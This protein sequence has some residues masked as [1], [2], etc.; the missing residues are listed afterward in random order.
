MVTR[1]L[2]ALI[3]AALLAPAGAQAR[4]PAK[5]LLVGCERSTELEER[6]G[7][8]EGEMR[9]VRGAA[10]MQM[11]FKLQVRT[12]ERDR[13]TAVSAPGFGG[14]LTSASGTSRYVYT[15]RVEN[16]IAPAAYR[17][18]IRFRWLDADGRRIA[19]A[20]SSS[21]RCT[22]PDPRPNLVVRAIGVERAADPGRRSYVVLVR[23]T[24]RTE[25]GASSLGLS[26]DGRV[27][28]ATPVAALAPGEYTLVTV[29][30]PACAA[31]APLE[32]TADPGEVVDERN[33]TDNRFSRAC[34]PGAARR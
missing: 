5:A 17:V 16:L 14:W 11:R 22:Q 33:E 10:R 24:G 8:F 21:R 18:Q 29:D 7:V 6:A 23:N 1:A 28:P 15:R 12:P 34:P 27:L 9:T 3:C 13:W 32:A 20:R 30:G 31:G 2:L 25:A 4:M 19:S 26:V